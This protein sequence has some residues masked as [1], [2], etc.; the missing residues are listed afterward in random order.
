MS[1]RVHD[2]MIA[3]GITNVSELA[4]RLELPRQTVYRWL[5]GDI[6]HLSVENLFRLADLLNVS[7]RWL[8]LGDVEPSKYVIKNETEVEMMSVMKEMSPLAREQWLTV[9]RS[10]LAVQKAGKPTKVNPF[11]NAR[12]RKI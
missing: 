8:A 10:L 1:A 3:H 12:L 2:A 9:G 6:K 4:R 7:A 11:P 5:T